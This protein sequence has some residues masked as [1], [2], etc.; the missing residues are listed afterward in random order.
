MSSKLYFG[1]LTLEVTR[2]H[3]QGPNK[4]TLFELVNGNWVYSTGQIVTK[5][6]EFAWLPEIVRKRAMKWLKGNKKSA[7]KDD[8]LLKMSTEQLK[9]VAGIESDDREELIKTIMEK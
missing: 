1:N 9:M 6:E 5:E 8:E 3:S 2:A 7:I 4:P